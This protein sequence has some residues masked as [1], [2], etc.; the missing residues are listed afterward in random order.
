METKQAV[1]LA[2]HVVRSAAWVVLA[3]G[4]PQRVPGRRNP[5]ESA[6]KKNKAR[7]KLHRDVSSVCLCVCVCVCHEVPYSDAQRRRS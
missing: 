6:I 2:D 3:L 4:R 7:R 5:S 1:L